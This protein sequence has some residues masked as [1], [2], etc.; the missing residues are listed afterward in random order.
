[1]SSL[2]DAVTAC[3]PTDGVFLHLRD[4]PVLEPQRIYLEDLWTKFQPYADR[5][6]FH[7][8]ALNFY[9]RY[10]E[11]ALGCEFL[12]QGF[13]LVPASARPGTGPDL[14]VSHEGRHIW[15]EAISPTKGQG[16]DAVEFSEGRSGWVPEESIVLRYRSGIEEKFAKY[17]RYLDAGV[18]APNDS[19]VVAVCGKRIP[20][21]TW[22]YELPYAL[23]A[24]LPFGP[25]SMTLRADTLE[26]LHTGYAHRPSIAK[27]SG[28]Q[29]TTT[30]FLD[31]R[32]AG[33]SAVVSSRPDVFDMKRP[34]LQL[35]YNPQASSP[36]PRPFLA[37]GREWW[38][39]GNEVKNDRRGQYA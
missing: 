30:V 21:G 32:Y 22:E 24:V 39:E 15:V 35:L 10:W 5:T 17:E 9:A 27:Q 37:V 28:N 16:K 29:V 34:Y 6:F 14:C 2:L 3:N 8:M 38:V 11:L 23:Q 25:L 33:L 19:Y 7:D 36:I 18:I 1:M 13:E 12:H 26:V 20:A 4:D 31:S